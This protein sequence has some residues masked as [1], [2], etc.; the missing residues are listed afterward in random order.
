MGFDVVRGDLVRTKEQALILAKELNYP[1]YYP[2]FYVGG[3]EA[4][5]LYQQEQFFAINRSSI[6]SASANNEILIEESII[7]WKRI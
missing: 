5:L 1:S 4:V 6:Q 3:Q 7:G 2:C